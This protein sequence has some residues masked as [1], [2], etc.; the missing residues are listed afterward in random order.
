[1][2]KYEFI[3]AINPFYKLLRNNHVKFYHE[4][5]K[6]VFTWTVND[7]EIIRNLIAKNIDGIITDIPLKAR[8]IVQSYLE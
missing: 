8:N 7:E 6:K 1:M 4:N 3:D 2:V 5:N